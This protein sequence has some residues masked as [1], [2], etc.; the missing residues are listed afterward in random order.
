M[1]RLLSCKSFK[2]VRRPAALIGPRRKVKPLKLKSSLPTESTYS[3]SSP[4]SQKK[5][6]VFK[7]PTV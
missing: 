7:L 1:S 6:A 2:S 5:T 4:G 3:F